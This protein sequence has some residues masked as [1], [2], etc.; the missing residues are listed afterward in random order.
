M[1]ILTLRK[2]NLAPCYRGICH[3]LYWYIP[4]FFL[5]W[6]FPF[7]DGFIKAVNGGNDVFGLEFLSALTQPLQGVV[8]FIVWGLEKWYGPHQVDQ[9]EFLNE[10]EAENRPLLQGNEKKMREMFF[11]GKQIHF[12][13]F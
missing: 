7:I 10:E 4:T 1:L 11:F 3:D 8:N 12:G 9:T 2:N 6:T 13:Y 5:V